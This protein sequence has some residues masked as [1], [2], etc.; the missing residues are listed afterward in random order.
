MRYILDDS[1]YI[2]SVSCTPFNCKDKSCTEYTGAI[3]DGYESIAEWAQ[4]ANI[5]AYKLVGGN[6]TFDAAKDAELTAEWAQC[7][8][9][10]NI[11]TVKLGTNYTMTNNEYVQLQMVEHAKTGNRL[12]IENGAVKIGAGISLVKVSFNLH[13]N[14][15]AT[16]GNKWATLYVNDSAEIPIVSYLSNRGTIS[17]GVVMLPVSEGDI[18]SLQANGAK[19]DVVRNAL[20]TAMT[21]EV[22]E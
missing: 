17:S 14:S 5:R 3:P 20:Y 7:T 9:G 19:N 8:S 6:L 4:N 10:K 18:I 21:V 15:V 12:T 11:I 2:D 22:V 1:G 13:F 16:A